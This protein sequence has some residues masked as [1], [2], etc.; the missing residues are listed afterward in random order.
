[1]ASLLKP[2]N[3]FLLATYLLLSAIPF[4][5]IAFGNELVN[6]Y[7]LAGAEVMAWITIWAIFKRPA[8]FHCMLLPAFIAVPLQLYLSAYYSQDISAHHLGIV[9]E[10]SPK[11][12]LEFLG[13]RLWLLGLV[14]ALV[15]AWFVGSWRVACSTR[16]LDWEDRSRWIIFAG[17]A[18]GYGIW[19]YGQ[20]IG[21]AKA[22]PT[23]DSITATSD[24]IAA[25]SASLAELAGSAL[26]AEEIEPA[27]TGAA[28]PPPSTAITGA[29][30]KLPGWAAPPLDATLFGKSWPF[31]LAI[32]IYEFWKERKYLGE[33]ANRSKSFR[34][35]ARQETAA[36][37]PQ[38]VIMVI[39]ESSRFDRWSLNG[40]KRETTPLLKKEVNLVSLADMVTAVSATRLSVPVILSRKP[41]TQSLEAGFSEKSFISAYKEAGFKTWWLSNQMSFGQ[42]DTPVSVFAREADVIQFLNPGGYTDQSSLDAVLLGPLKIAMADVSPKKLIVLH[43]LGNHWNYSHRHPKEFDRW[44]PSFFGV[45]NPDFSDRAKKSAL[46]NSYDNSILYNDWFLSSVI[47]SLKERDQLTSMMYVSDHGQILYDGSCDLAFHGHNTQHEFHVPALVWYSDQYKEVFPGKVERLIRNRSARLAT[48]NV[49][50]SLLDMS[51]IRY[52]TEQLERSL[53]SKKLR[54]HKRYVDSYGWTDYDNARFKGDCREVIARG[55]PLPQD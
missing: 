26:A 38:V 7:Q 13:S 1:M 42:F 23:S 6:A 51:D 18:I 50:H 17:L 8:W 34:F 54:R 49:F 16:D 45:K 32:P 43:S 14:A 31:G 4:L 21:I 11:E 3:F 9:L 53:F 44:R 19:L 22:E 5:S 29:L 27:D 25:T 52:Q 37:L 41:A 12:A 46:N 47:G 2:A 10:T 33:L 28:A 20:S 15:T 24:S 35:G 39:G 48:E 40:Y 30:P 36:D 55:K